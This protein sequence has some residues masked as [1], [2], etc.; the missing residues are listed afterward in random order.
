MK[1]VVTLYY[2]S[3]EKNF[4]DG[5]IQWFIRTNHVIHKLILHSAYMTENL[6]S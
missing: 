3:Y 6:V 1:A 4:G 5:F 2:D